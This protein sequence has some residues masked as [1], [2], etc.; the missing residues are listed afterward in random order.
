MT[1]GQHG[2]YALGDT[3]PTMAKNNETQARESKQI[4]EISPQFRL[5]SATRLHEAGIGSNRGSAG[6]GEYVLGS[7]THRPSSQ[8]SWKQLKCS[9]RSPK[10]S[11]AMGTKS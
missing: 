6:R 3:H 8:Q 11:P 5:E 10:L 1:S 7:C 2:A 4:S 9:A